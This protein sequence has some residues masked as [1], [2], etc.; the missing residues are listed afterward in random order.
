[1]ASVF[2]LNSISICNIKWRAAINRILRVA[3]FKMARPLPVF[4]FLCFCA[5][6]IFGSVSN[7]VAANFSLLN[8]EEAL[9]FPEIKK[10]IDN[11]QYSD[12]FLAITEK[13]NSKQELSESEK[14]SLYIS[15]CVV[16]KMLAKPADALT[17][18]ER[19]YEIDSSSEI[20]LYYLSLLNLSTADMSEASSCAVLLKERAP[21]NP[22]GYLISATIF[23][24]EG[25][26]KKAYDEIKNA[27]KYERDFFEA[28]AFLFSY[29]KKRK[30]YESARDELK[31]LMKLTPNFELA[32]FFNALDF[33]DR[34]S[35]EAVV[36]SEL[37]YEYGNL[38]Y[39]YFKNPKSALKYYKQSE[40]LNASHVKTKIG[41]AQYYALFG[42]Y[43]TAA[44]LLAEAVKLNPEDKIASR[45]YNKFDNRESVEIFINTN[46]NTLKAVAIST[47]FSFCPECG[48]ANKLKA[49]KCSNCRRIIPAEGEIK[50]EAAAG[51][52]KARLI[53]QKP[54]MAEEFSQS[55]EIEQKYDECLEAGIKNLEQKEYGEAEGNFKEMI[56]LM[57]DSPEGYNMLG[58]TYLATGDYD[59]AISNFKR[60]IALNSDF[61]EGYFSL[62]KTYEL[63]SKRQK[64]IEMYE[65]ALKIDSDYEEAAN[66]LKKIKSDGK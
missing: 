21:E 7:A 44:S 20:C 19:A 50:T 12:A 17:N 47:K 37:F 2:N 34:K 27:L 54:S 48:M 40:K 49:K 58:A 51:S 8:A 36:K 30:K 53:A 5:A 41:M 45:Y 33:T 59:V 10:M 32:P 16:L 6:L 14:L 43:E 25:R 31:K 28:R 66:A 55:D 56:L 46:I 38:M 3:N 29:Y 35:A 13:L 39:N 62:G 15:L 11:W 22:W 61:A 4:L 23:A 24:Y 18:I 57:P 26:A 1:M 65:K 52:E 63:T 42:Q 60:A 64:A 9:K